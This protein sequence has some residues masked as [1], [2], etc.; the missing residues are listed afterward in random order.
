MTTKR[1]FDYVVG[2]DRSDRM[3]D[4]CLLSPDRDFDPEFDQID[5]SPEALGAWL[6]DLEAL[7]PGM[8][9]AV[10][11]EMPA[12]ELLAFFAGREGLELY[13][14]NP[15]VPASFRKAFNTSRAKSDVLDCEILAELLAAHWRKLRVH[16]PEGVALRRIAALA[17]AR[18]GE[19]HRRVEQSNRLKSLLKSSF[20]QAL[21]LVGRDLHAPMAVGFLRR[22]PS[23]QD[24]RSADAREIAAF[25]RSAHCSSPKVI[26]TRVARIA[27]ATALTD[28]PAV[29]DVMRLRIESC[30]DHLDA[31]NATIAKYDERIAEAYARAADRTLYDSLPGAGP[32]LAPRLLA[33][34]GEDRGRFVSAAALQR[35]SGVAPVTVSSGKKRIVH[36]RY[37]RPKFLMQ[38]FVE[39]AGESIKWSAWAAAF[40]KLK[41]SQGMTYNCA[42]RELAY[43]WQRI[44]YR[45]WIDHEP[46]DERRYI[47]RLLAK[48]SPVCAFMKNVEET[49]MT[50]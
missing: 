18:R 40:W 17:E 47:E 21:D 20:P 32:A 16:R 3:L 15:A 24:A 13:A 50:A 4:I 38:T 9:P 26:E 6:A 2:I 34:L 10:I 46:Y 28:D 14:V 35:H 22:W 7:F 1:N 25:Y 29:M 19:V 23:L 37:S 48:G 41:K 27:N 12:P 45:M 11:F 36:R 43:K 49:D 5:N 42:M 39:Y 30:L 44:I 33:A 8:R 31:S